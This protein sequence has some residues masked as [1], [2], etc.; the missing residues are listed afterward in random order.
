MG[1]DIIVEL[2]RRG[3][4]TVGAMKQSVSVFLVKRGVSRLEERMGWMRMAA[5]EKA[6]LELQK[7][8]VEGLDRSEKKVR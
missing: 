2:D 5:P 8:M 7:A 4:M 3:D 6:V 1:T